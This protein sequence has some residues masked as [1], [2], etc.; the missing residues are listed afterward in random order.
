ML[1]CRPAG[2]FLLG[3]APCF[4]VCAPVP[5]QLVSQASATCRDTEQ[6]TAPVFQVRSAPVQPLAW[7]C[8]LVLTAGT[9]HLHSACNAC[10][11][12]SQPVAAR[13]AIT[14]YQLSLLASGVLALQAMQRTLV[15]GFTGVK[16]P[17]I[18]SHETNADAVK[19]PR[20]SC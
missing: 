12:Q 5:P 7:S 15:G 1:P 19:V 17:S 9:K 2:A 11:R 8:Q 18:Y 10:R 14:R 6:V 20:C 13:H 16:R 4:L 3:R